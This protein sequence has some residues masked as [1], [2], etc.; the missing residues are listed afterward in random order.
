MTDSTFAAQFDFIANSRRPSDLSGVAYSSSTK[1]YFLIQNKGKQ[2]WEMDQN[3]KCIRTI[4]IKGFGDSEDLAVVKANSRG[5]E[6][7]ILDESGKIFIGTVTPK[8]SLLKA[9][10]FRKIIF[11]RYLTSSYINIFRY[12]DTL[13][14][15]RGAEGITYVPSENAFYVVK[16]KTPMRILK[17]HYNAKRRTIPEKV[18]TQTDHG[19]FPVSDFSAVYYSKERDDLFVLSDE[20]NK[21]LRFDLRG[22]YISSQSLPGDYQWEGL[23]RKENEWLV[24]YEPYHY[25]MVSID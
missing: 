1:T 12:D 10:N 3:F 25:K 16:E 11:A 21:I 13:A 2:L 14:F 15:N 9:R 4:K 17:V 8:T 19:D 22:N 24:T 20:S 23:S 18:F 5:V 6:I 7:A